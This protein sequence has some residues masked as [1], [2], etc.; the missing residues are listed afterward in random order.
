MMDS[1]KLTSGSQLFHLALLDE[2]LVTSAKRATLLSLCL[3]LLLPVQTQALTIEAGDFVSLAQ[4]LRNLSFTSG[5][6]D[7]VAPT[8]GQQSNFRDLASSLL[9]SNVGMAD[10]QAAA[11]NY[12]LVQYTDLPSGQ[13]YLGVREI[14][15]MGNQTLGWGSYFVNQGYSSNVL[16]EVPHPRFDTNSWDI[17]ART[18]RQSEA[19]G[20][21]MAGAHRNANGSG[22]ADVAHKTDTIFHQVHEVWNGLNGETPAWSIHGFAIANHPTFPT[23]TD[24]V[25]SN[26]DGGVSSEVVSID[27]NFEDQGFLSHAYNTLHDLDPLNV[28]VNEAV[29]GGTFSGLGATTN[30]QGIYSRGIGG[31]FVHIEMEQSIRF[32]E[33]NRQLAADAITASLLES[34]GVP[35]PTSGVLLLCGSLWLLRLSPGRRQRTD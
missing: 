4:G 9:T 5:S 6:N 24:V 28:A 30:V 12:E 26:G 25:N 27:G 14:L 29:S 2:A 35:E 8:V 3:L 10:V 22:T 34:G 17:A 19:R 15:S 23:G 11:L 33:T 13:V 18:F 1:A 31:V 21:L 32:D 16:L 20:Y 7:Y